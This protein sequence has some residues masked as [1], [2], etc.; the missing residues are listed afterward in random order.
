MH[1]GNYLYQKEI[2]CEE[3]FIADYFEQF[4]GALYLEKPTVAI[5]WLND[6]FERI[7]HL[8]TDDYKIVFGKNSRLQVR[9]DYKAWSIDVI[10]RFI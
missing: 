3:E 6:V 7:L 10:G 8:I 2:V 9:Y 5:A 1:T 4:V